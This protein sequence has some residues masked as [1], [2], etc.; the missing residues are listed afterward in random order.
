[1]G[2]YIYIVTNLCH[3]VAPGADVP[4]VIR[5]S[6]QEI[7]THL[8][9]ELSEAHH[10]I[11][12]S[13]AWWTVKNNLMVTAGPDTSAYHLT[14][15]SHLISDTL[16][17]FLSHNSSPLPITTHENVKWSWLLINGIPT[18]VSPS[19]RPYSPSECLLPAGTCGR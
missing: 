4:L 18:G 2:F 15:A 19:H 7:V 12:L 10:P 14:Q 17:T 9:T 6:P 8:N 16:S 1:M 11:A 13:A 5:R 3:Y